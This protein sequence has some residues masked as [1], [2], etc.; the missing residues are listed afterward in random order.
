MDAKKRRCVYSD[1]STEKDSLANAKSYCKSIGGGL[2]KVNSILEIQD[3]LSNSMLNFFS[4][5]NSSSYCFLSIQ[6]LLEKKRYFWIDRISDIVN[7]SKTMDYPLG[8]CAKTSEFVNPNCIVLRYERILI[9]NITNYARCLSESDECSDEFAKP[10]CVDKHAMAD[11]SV[12]FPI[13]EDSSPVITVNT[14]TDYS[15][16]DDK[17]YHF[18]VDYCYKVGFHET[19]WIEAK[20]E[21]ERDNATLF[22]PQKTTT[23]EMI[24]ELFLRQRSYSS[25]GLA[26]L[27]IAYDYKKSTVIQYFAGYENEVGNVSG[28]DSLY[29]SC[30]NTFLKHYN[31]SSSS[32]DPSKMEKDSLRP[33]S[34]GC[35]Y[36]DFRS[37]VDWSIFCDAIRCKI[38]AAIIC[39]KPPILKTTTIVAKRLVS[40]LL[41]LRCLFSRLFS[42]RVYYIYFQA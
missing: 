41:Y 29:N 9:E 13:N 18:M 4:A 24:K 40:I 8:K 22:L 34:I 23:L 16:G 3:L 19:T 28:H 10:V 5:S 7:A 2:G 37:P 32:V 15:C 26:H 38:L 17:D 35:G 27:G 33:K 21:C 25:S 12:V 20:A 36:A 14:S 31:Y 11:L 6:N 1:I 39:Q 30:E 42:R